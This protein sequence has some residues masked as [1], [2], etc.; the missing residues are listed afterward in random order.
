MSTHTHKHGHIL[1]VLCTSKSLISS[2]CHYVKH[3]ISDH[4]AVFFTTTFPVRNSCRINCSKVRKHS[5]KCKF[6]SDIAN[7]ELIQTPYKTASPLSHQY[8]HIFRN[9]LDKHAPIHGSQTARFWQQRDT[10]ANSK[11]SGGNSAINR[12]NMVSRPLN[13]IRLPPVLVQ[14]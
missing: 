6:I 1:D 7:S 14:H 13:P 12:S 8:F 9:L 2:V 5:K 10:N 11:G 4:L 3:G